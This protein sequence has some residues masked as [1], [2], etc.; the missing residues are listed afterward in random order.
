[1]TQ[2]PL[3]ASINR[4]TVQEPRLDPALFRMFAFDL[5][6]LDELSYLLRYADDVT[7]LNPENATVSL[8]LQT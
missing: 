5:V 7:L 2:F 1:M 8:V 4:S 3:M 6:T